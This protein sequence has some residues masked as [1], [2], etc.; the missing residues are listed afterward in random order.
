MTKLTRKSSHKRIIAGWLEALTSGEYKQTKGALHRKKGKKEGFCCLGVLCDLAV[1]AKVIPAP[2]QSDKTNCNGSVSYSYEGDEG[3]LP[4]A[5]KDW[6]GLKTDCG[7]FDDEDDDESLAGI[8]DDGKKFATIAKIIASNP[9]GL[10][11]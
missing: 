4:D 7:N 1:K 9:E 10:F 11:V 6:A 3:V 8:N 2:E 5:V